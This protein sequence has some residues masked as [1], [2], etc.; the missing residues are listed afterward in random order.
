MRIIYTCPKCGR[1]LIDLVLT[2][3]PP[4][5]KKECFSCGWAS[6]IEQEEIV[7]VP[8]GGNSMNFGNDSRT[9]DN[10]RSSPCTDCSN[11]PLNR[12]NGHRDCILGGSCLVI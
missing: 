3:N 11:N 2:S 6:E 7:R 12:G 9:L 10:I 5:C 8:F 1:D 4:Q